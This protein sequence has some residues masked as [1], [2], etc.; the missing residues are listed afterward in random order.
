LSA[1]SFGTV[2]QPNYYNFDL[3]QLG[4]NGT[5][6]LTNAFRPAFTN[7]DF[8]TLASSGSVT[9]NVTNGVA[10]GTVYVLTSTNLI[11]PLSG[12]ITNSTTTFDGN[13]DLYNYTITVD[14]NQPATFIKLQAL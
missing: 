6:T 13:G 14:T 8:S 10:N 4:V 1:S 9:L 5:I 11:L 7:V 2:V 12:W 3:S